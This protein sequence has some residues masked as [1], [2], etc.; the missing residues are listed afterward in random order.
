MTVTAIDAVVAHVVLVAE[1]D[2]LL[3]RDVLVRQITSAGQAHHTPESQG[4]EQ[5][6]KK[7][8]EPRDEIRTAVKNLGHVKFA[9]LRLAQPKGETAVVHLVLTGVQA[10]VIIDAID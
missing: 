2:G 9:L 8:T 5:R 10:R 6:P 7:D 4:C 1:L 3:A